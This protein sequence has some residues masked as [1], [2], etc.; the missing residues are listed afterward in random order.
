M[1]CSFRFIFSSD[2]SIYSTCDRFHDHLR[3]VISWEDICKMGASATAIFCGSR[4][5]FIYI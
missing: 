5:E 2:P 3:D 1:T 4:S